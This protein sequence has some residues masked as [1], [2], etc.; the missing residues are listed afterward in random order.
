MTVQYIQKTLQEVNQM[1]L[2][3][4]EKAHNILNEVNKVVLGKKAE[5][6]EIMTSFLSNGHV[7]LED[8]PGVGK[9]TL[10]TAFL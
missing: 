4:V 3:L 6:A 2:L 10:A 8:I 7:L 9:T 1:D 5:T